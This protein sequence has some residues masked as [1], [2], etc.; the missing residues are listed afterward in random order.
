MMTAWF[1]F[2]FESRGVVAQKLA[3]QI[4]QIFIKYR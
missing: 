3:N 2:L 1:E 4:L